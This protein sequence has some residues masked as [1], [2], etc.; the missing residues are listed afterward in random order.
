M[1]QNSNYVIPDQK[2]LRNHCKSTDN[3]IGKA[4]DYN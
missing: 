4:S 3:L 1:A 2:K